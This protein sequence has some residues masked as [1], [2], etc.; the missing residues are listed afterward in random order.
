MS[1]LSD[2]RLA[3][4]GQETY[5][6]MVRKEGCRVSVA[7]KGEEFRVD[8]GEDRPVEGP[9]LSL[10]RSLLARAGDESKSSQNSLYERL[11][12]RWE[13]QLQV[14]GSSRDASEAIESSSAEE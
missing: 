13:E 11:R 8:S 10:Q 6:P 9:A 14:S 12:C 2:G 3:L 4:G 1:E 5:V 7:E